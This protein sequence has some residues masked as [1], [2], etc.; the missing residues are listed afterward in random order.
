MSSN[1]A[2]Y[3]GTFDPIHR[4][5]IAVA[6][7]A[8]ADRR[9]NLKGIYFVPAS[10]PPHKQN[11]PITSYVD[12][13]N[14]V[15]LAL[16]ETNEPRFIASK[17]ESPE[18]N[19]EVG[20]QPNYSIDS[21]RRLKALIRQQRDMRDPELYFVVGV[22]SFLQLGSWRQPQEL[23]K[24]C[25]FIIAS[26]P[27]FTLPDLATSLITVLSAASEQPPTAGERFFL[28]PTVAEVVS[29]TQIRAAVRSRL[30]LKDFVPQSVAKYIQEHG[31]YR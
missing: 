24:E 11:Q 30:P 8:L 13:L 28:L 12:R 19:S 18:N 27:G 3:G 31:L 4:G 1:F 20:Q 9:F 17:L 7:A 16:R 26:R 5:H 6:Q 2:F 14:M 22:D 23:M 10:I 21:I 25:K 15:E 29:S